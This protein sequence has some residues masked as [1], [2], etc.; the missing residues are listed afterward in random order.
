MIRSY[1][2]IKPNEHVRLIF[3]YYLMSV[4]YTMKLTLQESLSI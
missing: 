4:Q 1:N 3:D 2:L